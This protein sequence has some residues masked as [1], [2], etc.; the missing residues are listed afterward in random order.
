E[1]GRR[2]LA[3][4]SLGKQ[5]QG[6]LLVLAKWQQS[7]SNGHAKWQRRDGGSRPE[8]RTAAISVS[9]SQPGD[10][11]EANHPT[12]SLQGSKTRFEI[13]PRQSRVEPDVG[14]DQF[15]INGMPA[16]QSRSDCMTRIT[17]QRS[18]DPRS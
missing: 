10:C 1:V 3:P 12:L 2:D 16:A 14:L 5:G 6:D 15:L 18:R 11:C 17:Q 4:S 9:V 13:E 7:G 8:L